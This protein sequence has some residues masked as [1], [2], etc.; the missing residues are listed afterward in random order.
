MVEMLKYLTF[1][2]PCSNGLDTASKLNI[3]GHL[4]TNDSFRTGATYTSRLEESLLIQTA[5]SN[6]NGLIAFGCFSF[7][8]S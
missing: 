2:F 8:N 5:E 7:L 1:I 3:N 6:V 4:K